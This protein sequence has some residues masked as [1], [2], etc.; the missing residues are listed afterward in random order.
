MYSALKLSIIKRLVKNYGL[1]QWPF[2]EDGLATNH[3]CDFL[4]DERFQRAYAAAKSTNS[5]AIDIHWRAY[6]VAW[7]ANKGIGLE[8]DFVECGVNK[9]GTAMMAANYV[10]FQHQCKTFW[11]LDTFKGLDEKYV[12]DEEKKL[13]V[14][15]KKAKL[16]SECYEHIKDTFKNYPNVQIIRGS[17]PDTLPQVTA[18]KV[19]YLS[20]DMNCKVPEIAALTYFWD[21]LVSGAVVVLDDYGFPGHGYQKAAFDEFATSRDVQVLTLPTGQGVIVK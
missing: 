21:K 11:L 20:I 18:Q 1:T 7:A 14:M 9:G 2:I 5:W 10:S 6:V 3:N 8:G 16:Y 12:T 15:V 19:A 17:I 13:G 4:R